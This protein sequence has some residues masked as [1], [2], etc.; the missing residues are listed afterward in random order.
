MTW[1]MLI[2]VMI[3]IIMIVRVNMGEVTWKGI[4]SGR[5]GMMI[6]LISVYGDL[7]WILVTVSGWLWAIGVCGSGGR[8]F[9]LVDGLRISV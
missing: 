3:E 4:G 7:R 9:G 2:V 8:S 1:K 5:V 6:G